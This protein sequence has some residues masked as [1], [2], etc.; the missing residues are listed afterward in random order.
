MA[1]DFGVVSLV[2]VPE[3]ERMA[4]ER[5]LA[6]G[7]ATTPRLENLETQRSV[8]S[9]MQA[10]EFAWLADA[11]TDEVTEAVVTV[12][13][14]DDIPTVADMIDAELRHDLAYWGI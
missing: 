3:D 4:M 9:E 8:I 13:R 5:V 12:T 1:R 14:Q 2:L 6:R 10:F 7:E 11:N